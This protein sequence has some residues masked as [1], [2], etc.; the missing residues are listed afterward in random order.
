MEDVIFSGSKVVK[1]MNNAEVTL[2][3]DNS[4]NQVNIPA[5]KIVITRQIQ[6]G[7]GSKYYINGELAKLRE[8]REITMETGIAKS[9]LAI[10]SQGTIS[11][12]AQSSPEERRAIFEEAAGTSK[13]KKRKAEALRKLEHTSEA[14]DKMKTILFEL[15]KQLG[16]LSRQADKAKIFLDKSKKLKDIEVALI[17][18]DVAYYNKLL[19]ELEHKLKN[20]ISNKEEYEDQISELEIKF[21]LKNSYKLNLENDVISLQSELDEIS[22]KL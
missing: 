17:A 15:E 5:K 20:V 12:I 14:L 22:S 9:S 18:K 8:I 19:K 2:T 4:D 3:F 1:A 6:R 10:I 13:Y 11:S 16:P 21:D 7:K